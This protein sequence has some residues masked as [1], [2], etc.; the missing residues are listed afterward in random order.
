MLLRRRLGSC[1]PRISAAHVGM[2]RTHPLVDHLLIEMA[3]LWVHSLYYSFR[4]NH[5]FGWEANTFL[6]EHFH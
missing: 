2:L 1:D 6:Q 3:L 4:R 5:F